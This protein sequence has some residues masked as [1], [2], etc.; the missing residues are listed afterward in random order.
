[1]AGGSARNTDNSVDNGYVPPAQCASVDLTSATATPTL[2]P[3]PT[4]APTP[5]PFESFAGETS[6]P[7]ATQT[8][9]PT[10]TQVPSGG[11]N[12]SGPAVPLIL[13]ALSSILGAIALKPRQAVRQ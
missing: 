8:P 10:S 4:V 7:V 5:T 12:G 6:V 11:S 1:V 9:P 3:T 2:A 13:L